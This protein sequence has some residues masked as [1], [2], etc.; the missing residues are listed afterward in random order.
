MVY[1]NSL[2]AGP[3]LPGFQLNR[4]IAGGDRLKARAETKFV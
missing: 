4:I 2:Q 3:V 1:E